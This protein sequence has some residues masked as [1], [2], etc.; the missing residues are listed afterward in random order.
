MY[1]DVYVAQSRLLEDLRQVV[2]QAVLMTLASVIVA[3][4]TIDVPPLCSEAGEEHDDGAIDAE[5]ATVKVSLGN[6][7]AAVDAERVLTCRGSLLT[8]I[9]NRPVVSVSTAGTS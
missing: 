6:P 5:R 8:K 9:S 1:V 7:H 2:P 4:L 3:L